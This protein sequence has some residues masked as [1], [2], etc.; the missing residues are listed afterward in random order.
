MAS[1]CF[2]LKDI[3]DAFEKLLN[4]EY[5]YTLKSKSSDTGTQEIHIR[6]V[7]EHLYHLSGLHHFDDVV[8][9]KLFREHKRSSKDFF[10]DLKFGYLTT[11]DIKK[12]KEF[13]LDKQKRLFYLLDLERVLDTNK[14]IYAFDGIIHGKRDYKSKI[15]AKF[16]LKNL[17]NCKDNVFVFLNKGA[18]ETVFSAVSIISSGDDYSRG[19]HEECM[20]I[21]KKFL[22]K[23]TVETLFI[24]PSY[25]RNHP[26]LA[27]TELDYINN[28]PELQNILK[29]MR[30]Q[31]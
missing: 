8:K 10:Y 24:H 21:K 20:L 7:R 1:Y 2:E 14:E 19:Q 5:I 30:H 28:S 3:A 25:F 31:I 23:N 26:E 17:E 13:S 11:D 15:K 22:K 16:L 9:L 29:E 12:S 27:N 18:G 4:V 6:F